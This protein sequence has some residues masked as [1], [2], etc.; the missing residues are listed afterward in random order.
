MVNG[1]DRDA[2]SFIHSSMI[3]ATVAMNREAAQEYVATVM[4]AGKKAA[5]VG[6]LRRACDP[7][8]RLQWEASRFSWRQ[9]VFVIQSLV[10]QLYPEVRSIGASGRYVE[11]DEELWEAAERV[12]LLEDYSFEDRCYELWDLCE[13][14]LVQTGGH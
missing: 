12:L 7:A 5:L 13:S 11:I 2:R 9:Q 14:V 6:Y 1:G 10:E 4:E 3:P 8:R